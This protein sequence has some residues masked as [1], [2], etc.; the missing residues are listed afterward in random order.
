MMLVVA[1]FIVM[2]I[3]ATICLSIRGP[4][5]QSPAYL[6]AVGVLATM[7]GLVSG[8]GFCLLIGIPMCSLVFVTPFLI[9][10][11]KICFYENVRI[12]CI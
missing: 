11:K 3:V 10:G 5:A 7:L 2:I 6:S 9:I 12:I 8:F 1:T 4:L